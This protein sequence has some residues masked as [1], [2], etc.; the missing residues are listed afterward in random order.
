MLFSA[1]LLTCLNVAL[2]NLLSQVDITYFVIDKSRRYGVWE[3]FIFV[4]I[5]RFDKSNGFFEA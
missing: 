3:V 2:L 4:I 1:F 5:H